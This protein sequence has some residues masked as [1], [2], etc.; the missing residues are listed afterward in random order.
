MV[1]EG[2]DRLKDLLDQ[3]EVVY[4]CRRCG[5]T[6]DSSTETCSECQSETIVQHRIS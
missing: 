2:V 3:P 6:V 5:T 1:F 4:E